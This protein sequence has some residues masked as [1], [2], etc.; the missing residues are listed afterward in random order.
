MHFLC[1]HDWL[2]LDSLPQDSSSGNTS[3][4]EAQEGGGGQGQKS[5]GKDKS[6]T[7]GKDSS[8]RHSATHKSTPGYKVED[9][10]TWTLLQQQQQQQHFFY[11]SPPLSTTTTPL[12][13]PSCHPSPSFLHFRLWFFQIDIFL[14]GTTWQ[15][16]MCALGSRP[17]V[18][19]FCE[20]REA[21]PPHCSF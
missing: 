17:S 13:H 11:P 3:D 10:T 14:A 21:P 7:P 5:K 1:F 19:C 9:K 20:Y 6:S 12:L 15:T 4:V 8:H 16:Q 18:F 2:P